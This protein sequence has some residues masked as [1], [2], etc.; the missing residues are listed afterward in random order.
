[1]SRLRHIIIKDISGLDDNRV[2][3]S[4]VWLVQGLLR[5]ESMPAT[6]QY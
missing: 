1:M 6:R 4:H 5:H 2:N 3:G